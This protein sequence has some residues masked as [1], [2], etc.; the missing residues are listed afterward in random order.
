M[1]FENLSQ[2]LGAVFKKLKGRGVVTEKDIKE[3]MREIKLALLEADVNYKV[4]K[5]FVAKVSER[6][7]G[8]DVLES[9]TPGQQIIKIVNDELTALMGS[10]GSRI[11][12]GKS[13]T[14]VLLAGLQGAGKTTFCAKLAGLMR[15]KHN[16]RP[17]LVACDIY[18][19]AAIK[20][21][22]VVGKQ[23]DIPVFEMG[24]EQRAVDI[25]RA[26]I[27][28]AKAHGND[29]VIIDTAGRLHID[30]GLMKELEDIKAAV[31]PDEILLVIDAMTGQDAVNI[32]ESFNNRLEVTGV[33][34]TKLDGDTRGGA[35]L[36]VKAVTGKPIKFCGVGE[37]LSD[38]EE[39]HPDRMASRILG[40]GDV[41]SL[42]EKAQE[43]YDEK[44]AQ[45]LEEKIR[46]NTFNLDDFLNQMQQMKK[47]G[48]LSSLLKMVPGVDAKALD[49]ANI[50]E[51]K[52]DRVEAIIKS[53]TMQEREKP[54]I[55][56]AS[57][58]KRIAAG[59]G[60]QVSDV[61]L[62]L[63]QFEQMQKMMKQLGG[64]AMKRFKKKKKKK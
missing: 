17:L 48:P 7:V 19:P 56:N 50:D 5:D 39:F 6:C 51:K 54:E 18:R 27:E 3:S 10:E 9:L 59:S 42:I 35:A 14:V 62:L 28:H 26:S 44:D 52:L 15:K 16:K 53:M 34:V 49:S 11:E 21:L 38:I 23:L 20:Q 63:K 40:S 33:I 4:V 36:S 31:N 46:Q 47:M 22:Q 64:G 29:F 2:K 61:N 32:A 45:A 1:A 12:F 24:T 57:R 60:N 37:K 55:I 8:A 30:D 25:A 58:K 41:M 43:A 13:P